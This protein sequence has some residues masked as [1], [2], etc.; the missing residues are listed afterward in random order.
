MKQFLLVCLTLTCGLG[1]LNAEEP[2][3]GLQLKSP[4]EWKGE[5]ISL[6]P[7][8]SPNMTLKGTEVIRFAPGMFDDKSDSFFSY[9]F[10]FQV[11][12]DQKLTKKLIQKELLV[13][14]Q[15]LA[16]AVLK[17]QKVKF[18][19]KSF[20]LKLEER[21]A[22]DAVQLADTK[23][24]KGDLKWLEPFVTRKS[25]TLHLELNA[26]QDGK[27]KHDYVFVCVS[28]K[29]TTEPIWKEMRA[30]RQSFYESR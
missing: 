20:T 4:A 30:I 5:T 13:Y 28:P 11:K 8:F 18:D 2:A 1:F 15:G 16:S 27:S 23:K 22:A 26:W 6:P 17:D 21:K 24:Y 10:V 7:S 9:V 19:P 3:D 12:Q 29:K 14:Y 25:Q